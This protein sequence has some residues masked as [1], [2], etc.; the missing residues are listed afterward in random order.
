ML[1]LYLLSVYWITKQLLLIKQLMPYSFI[2][3]VTKP[4]AQVG[5]IN[6]VLLP[7]CELLGKA[8]RN[9]ELYISPIQ[10]SLAHYKR[11]Q[12]K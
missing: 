5:F 10:D 8:L 1:F 6:F 3:K 9:M 7:L 2:R 4:N 11:L 12:V